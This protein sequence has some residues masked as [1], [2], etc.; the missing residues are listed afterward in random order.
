MSTEKGQKIIFIGKEKAKGYMD[1]VKSIKNMYQGMSF[2]K[3]CDLGAEIV[4]H[5]YNELTDEEINSIKD[6]EDFNNLIRSKT[7]Q[8][9]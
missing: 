9:K 6:G 7:I 1:T 3:M 4:E 8:K 5:T 2:S